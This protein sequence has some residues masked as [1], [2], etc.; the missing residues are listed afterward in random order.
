MGTIA[1]QITSLAIVY[2]TVYSYV[3]QRNHQSSASL[4]FVWGIHRWPVNSPH[5]WP[6]TR[7]MFP[8]HESWWTHS[9]IGYQGGVSLTFRELQNILSKLCVAEIVLHMIISSWNFVRVPKAMVMRRSVVRLCKGPVMLKVFPYLNV[10]IHWPSLLDYPHKGPVMWNFDIF[11]AVSTC[12]SRKM[13]ALCEQSTQTNTWANRNDYH[14]DN[15]IK[16]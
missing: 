5:K 1:S 16:W 15:T 9:K 14:N 10:I 4:A 11:F 7:K 8:F 2:S 6:V 3:D 12:N 13:Y